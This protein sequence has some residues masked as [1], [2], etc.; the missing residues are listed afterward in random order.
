MTT[1]TTARILDNPYIRALQDGGLGLDDFR[2]T[3][4]QFYF[5]VA[6]Y[7]RP[8]AA[9]AARLSEPEDRVGLLQNLVEEHGDFDPRAF[10]QATFARLLGLIGGRPPT[11]QEP[12]VRAFNA[13]LWG[14]CTDAE[15]ELG[16]GCLGAIESTFADASEA[17]GEAAVAR[18]WVDGRRLIHYSL[19]AAVDKR[20]ARELWEPLGRRDPARQ[21][22]GRQGMELGEFLLD[23]L[24]RDLLRNDPF[25][26]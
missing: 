20:H 3:Q 13:A 23:R 14:V 17:I 5:A 7:P 25:L 4:E 19:H 15:P 1:A 21:V 12:P 11:S 2:R 24:Y 22:F 6:F 16:L 8:L 18:G 9:L 10:H 26:V